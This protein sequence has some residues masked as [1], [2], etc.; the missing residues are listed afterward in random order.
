MNE[1]NNTNQR[2]NQTVEIAGEIAVE[3][4]RLYQPYISMPMHYQPGTSNNQIGKDRRVLTMKIVTRFGLTSP[5][6]ISLLYGIPHRLALEHLNKLVSDKLLS[7]VITHRSIDG[8]VYVLDYAGAK[9]AE[10]LLSVAVYFR[11]GEPSLRVN[12]NTIMH[13]LM[14]QYVLLKGVHNQTKD[15]IAKPYWYSFVT[16]PEFKRLFK[17]NDVRNV[18]GIALEPDG[19]I[20][21]VEIEHSFK[22]KA[23]RQTILLKWLYGLKHGYYSKVMLFSQSLQIFSDIKRLHN[24]LYEEMPTR[25]DKK[26]RQVLLSQE[27]AELLKGNI[28]HRTVLC[29]ELATIFY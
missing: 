21:A 19:T 8:R 9:Y 1:Q 12:Q 14:M 20:A 23:A 7:L 26:T 3:V 5:T 2:L 17:S 29:E 4:V 18:D 16:E 22:T 13:D 28:V 10:E 11:T 25:F 6:I 24:Q 27:D 15:N